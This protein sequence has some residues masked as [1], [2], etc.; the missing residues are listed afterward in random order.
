MDDRKVIQAKI[1]GKDNVAG[2]SD[3]IEAKSLIKENEEQNE[4]IVF[5][6][7]NRYIV[8]NATRTKRMIVAKKKYTPDKSREGNL[9]PVMDADLASEINDYDFFFKWIDDKQQRQSWTRAMRRSQKNSF[10]RMLSADKER[11]KEELDRKGITYKE[12]AQERVNARNSRVDT[13]V[14]D[15][16]AVQDGEVGGSGPESGVPNDDIA[17]RDEAETA[18]V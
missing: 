16:A 3:A 2:P 6:C 15:V 10:K 5:K 14:S 17:N 4:V 11:R 18:G 8:M 1:L 13:P 9:K 7:V 12:L